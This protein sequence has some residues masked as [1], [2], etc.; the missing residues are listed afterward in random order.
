M[1][2]VPVVLLAGLAAVLGYVRL[3]H[4]PIS[5]KF[6]VG[7]I[8]R[9]LANEL[10][11]SQVRIEDALVR[12]TDAGIVE[13]R[14]SNVRLSDRDGQPIASA[15]LA[16]VEL[17]AAALWQAQIA[18]TRI[19]LIEPKLLLVYS[20]E[21]GLSLSFA[22]SGT[23]G[24]LEPAR[25]A[26]PADAAPSGSV[27]GLPAALQ[28]IDLA[29]ALAEASARARRGQDASSYMRELGLR[30]ATVVVQQPDGVTAWRVPELTI[31]LEHKQKRSII[32]GKVTIISGRAPWS[33]TFRTEESEK[34]QTIQVNASIR[35]LVP[36]TLARAL[37]ELGLLDGFDLPVGGNATFELSRAGD[38]LSGALSLE[39]SRGRIQLPWLPNVNF[40][41]DAGLVDLRYHRDRARIEL[42]P[43]TVRWGQSH[44]TLVGNL[45]SQK[46]AGGEGWAF[47]LRAID[48]A[49][50][51]EEFGIRQIPLETWA[52]SGTA[53]P[54][55]RHFELT[56]FELKAG[57][58]DISLSGV[59]D[60]PRD[61]AD[62]RFEGKIGAMPLPT[63]K[64][65][66][67][68]ALAPGAR[69]W[70]GERVTRGRILGGTFRWLSGRH[71]EKQEA[72][73]LIPEQRLSL[74]VEATDIA[75]R[76]MRTMS[77]VEAPRALIRLEGGAIE[78]VMPDAAVIVSNTKRVP[79]KGGRFTAVD[80]FS[81]RP[82]GEIVFRATS[83][84]APV[85]ELI[86][87]DP[88]SLIKQAGIGS[89]EGMDGKIDGQ[90]KLS[91]PLVTGVD[92]SDVKA[93]GKFRLT[94]GRARQLV[95]PYDVQGATVNIEFADRVAEAKGDLLVAGVPSKVVWAR[96]IDQN[97]VKSSQIKLSAR[98]DNSD[99]NQLGLDVNHLLQGEIPVEL[100][101]TPADQAPGMPPQ[102]PRVQLRADLT[103]AE[104]ILSMIAWKKPAGSR[105]DVQVDIARSKGRT[106]FNDLQI[107]GDNI[108]A[109]G[110]VVIG[111][112]KR[113]REFSF[114]SFTLDLVSQLEMYGVV[115]SDTV[116]DVKVKG[117]HFEGREFFRSL[118]SLG[119]ITEKPLPPLKARAGVDL[120]AEIETLAGFSEV[121]LRGLRLKLSKRADKL[122]A[123]DAR[124]TL[125]GGKPLTVSLL[126]T[127]NQPRRLRADSPDAGQ[128]MR[129]V[130]FYP[131][132]QGG[133][134][135]LEV[136]LDGTGL[137]EKTGTLIVDDYRIWGDPVASEVLGSVDPAKA[138]EG[139][140]TGKRQ[141]V[142]QAFDF[143][144]MMVPFS[145]GQGQFVFND[146]YMRGALFGVSLRGKV[147]FKVGRMNVDGTYIP[148]QG[149]NNVL[150]DIPLIGQIVS[151]PR[152]DGIFGITF[153]VQGSLQQP[154]VIVNP[155]SLVTPGIF[156]T[157]M[158]MTGGDQRITPRDETKQQGSPQVRSVGPQGSA[159]SGTASGAAQ[160]TVP[161]AVKPEVG[162]GW[163][164]QSSPPPPRK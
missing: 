1:L 24:E 152:G 23:D 44:V 10:G 73:P 160:A 4:G 79:L 104:L 102:E 54:E 56:R 72:S 25:E 37:P 156:R 5:L 145:V 64:A 8:E 148:L 47:D 114:P 110:Q 115:R 6:L 109:S 100:T 132:M 153:L 136:N 45:S 32:S 9:G 127:P 138:N 103:N 39:I 50:A 75:M 141:V 30:N 51:A 151:G 48:G 137:A 53:A 80:I 125:D 107:R 29:R 119:Q 11:G 133:H 14:L 117:R 99:R 65:I 16:A 71:L 86:D 164:S 97:G 101:V 57:G 126:N 46:A 130:G 60:A 28:R 98:L 123:V 139:R 94:E 113:L 83:S 66:W 93:E 128:A 68:R 81:E 142:R 42:A 63:L 49:I 163:S 140:S 154:Q 122:V 78:V 62:A 43:S 22:R 41:V 144:R 84:L 146:S 77:P 116:L 111:A 92:E 95:G 124:G 19:E 112:D 55:R 158:E 35:D 91:L 12:L 13:F 36:R 106:E 120:S 20:E 159:K 88:L 33:L 58:A 129:L 155:L 27:A 149:L 59:I 52:A 17:S 61:T 161:R 135:R 85:L 87:Q 143:N 34:S 89:I 118:F 3:S 134:V 67:P 105:A 157:L 108:T 38:V 74:A 131:N 121:S 162:G 31:D 40:P 76:P 15:P 2:L 147:D 96:T 21:G 70:V 150:G 90:V 82:L 7:P 18:P 26:A 69:L